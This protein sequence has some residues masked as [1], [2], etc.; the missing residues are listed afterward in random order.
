MSRP[1]S[2]PPLLFFILALPYGISFGFVTITLPF[3]LTKA[4]VSVAT[5]AGI[6]A[7]GMSAY[8]WRFLWGPVVDL[9]FSLRRWYLIGLVAACG[10]LVLLGT[11]P[12]KAGALLTSIVLL[13]QVATTFMVNP[14][15]GMMA[16]TVADEQKGRAAGWYQAGVTAGGALGGGAGVWMAAHYS[17]AVAS[18]VLAGAMLLAVGALRF[19]PDVEAVTTGHFASRLRDL[20]LGFVEMLR[21]ANSLLV[22][23]VVLSPIGLGAAN[24]LWSS[25]ATDWHA[26]PDRV[27]V[28]TGLFSGLVGAAGCAV[29]GYFCDRLGR[30]WM[31]FGGGMLIALVAVLMAATPRTPLFYSSGVLAYAFGL[32]TTNAAYSALVLHTTGRKSASTRFAVLGSLGN[33][34]TVYLVALDGW[35]H[36][37]WGVGAMLNIEA[38]L[39]VVCIAA[40]LGILHKINRAASSIPA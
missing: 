28:V 19:V 10:S 32:G 38:I 16:H 1:N 21:S 31:F 14:L 34:P 11:V 7:I 18:A 39:G 33:V 29:G 36:D 9:T 5:T 24:Y 26:S 20:G 23:A 6:V 22:V 35:T 12:P 3:V 4:G 2:A 40:A 30:W 25:V 27:A 37:R 8:V 13:S 15:G 17:G